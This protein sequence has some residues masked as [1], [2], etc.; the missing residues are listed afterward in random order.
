MGM[1]LLVKT[2]SKNDLPKEPKNWPKCGNFAFDESE[3]QTASFFSA[4]LQN[5]ISNILKHL[6]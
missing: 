2:G 1:G 3:E 6:F 4:I 5:I